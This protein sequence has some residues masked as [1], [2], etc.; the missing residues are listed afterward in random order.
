MSGEWIKMRFD[1]A[2]DPAVVGIARRLDLDEFGVVG[3]LHTIWSW[4]DRQTTDGDA[5]SVTFVFIDR[6]VNTPNFA[7]AME[8][9]G[10]L[11]KTDTGVRFPNFTRHNGQTAKQRALTARRMRDLRGRDKE[12]SD[13]GRDATS[14]APG[15]TVS[16]SSSISYGGGGVGEGE[17]VSIP[18]ELDTEAFHRAWVE[19]FAYRREAHLKAYVPRGAKAQLTRLA[20]FGEERAIAAIQHSIANGYKGIF[21]PTSAPTACGG[22]GESGQGFAVSVGAVMEQRPVTEGDLREMGEIP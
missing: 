22:N 1:L 2:D 5:A 11:E 17:T 16:S 20:G 7:E 10:W 12:K 3:R 6:K 4:A 14:D 21:E 15:V 9:E 19:W 8:A 18:K 13:A